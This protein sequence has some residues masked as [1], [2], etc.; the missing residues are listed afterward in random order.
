MTAGVDR[1]AQASTIARWRRWVAVAFVLLGTMRIVA[2]YRE[3]SETVDEVDHIGA[4]MEWFSPGTYTFELSHP[5]LA[6]IAAA[7]GPFLLGIRSQHQANQWYEGRRVLYADNAYRR[8]L[9]AARLGMLPFFFLAAFFVWRI[10]CTLF[11]PSVALGAVACFTLLPPVLAHFGLATTDGPLFTMFAASIYAMIRWLRAPNA[12]TGL[13]V[14][15][16]VGLAVV[17]KFSA[18]LFLGIAAVML[19]TARLWSMGIRTWPWRRSLAS[20]AL[21]GLAAFIVAWAAYRFS[22]GTVRGIPVP[23][24]EIP[25]GIRQLADHNRYGH[26]AYFLGQVRAHGVWYFFPVVI[27]IK[28]PIAALALAAVGFAVLSRRAGQMR[29]W[30]RLVPMVIVVAVLAVSMGAGLNIGVR[31]VL[32][33]YV[34][35]ALAAGV[36]W[37][38]L[39]ARWEARGVRVALIAGTTALSIGTFSIHPDYL[40]YFN[41]L[42]GRDPSRL[43]ADSDLDWG[44]DLFRLA[45]AVRAQRV[46]TLKFA[47]IGTADLSPIVG[48]PV[49]Y[50]DGEGRPNGWVA[51]AE[52]WYR[53][54]NITFRRGEYQMRPDAMFW[55]DSAGTLTRV[56]KGIRLYHVVPA[57]GAAPRQ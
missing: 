21:A 45:R 34:G 1:R 19:L 10:G 26:P 20:F 41:A 17:A 14:G 46:D 25:K 12:R 7:A 52:T 13:A 57:D 9:T 56:G 31:H 30:E 44:Q 29:S 16:A 43:V 27:A 8:N 51:V 32:P 5:P 42:A 50:W 23:L 4:G 28:T 22:L 47:Y 37:Q 40:A 53:R 35:I 33:V 15:V 55:L 36:A 38:W 11:N 39:W 48:V 2:T 18:L 54:G 3:L 24:S 6:R 49:E